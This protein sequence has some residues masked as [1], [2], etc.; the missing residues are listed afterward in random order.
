MKNIYSLLLT[1]TITTLSLFA[2]TPHKMSYQAIIRDS[3]NKLVVNSEI[4][5]RIS[6]LQGSVFGASVYIETLT[7]ETNANG[8]VT[9]EIGSE[10]ATV[11]TGDF[12]QINWSDG[13][14]FIKTETDPS[15]GTNYTITGT[16]QLLSVPFALHSGT[17]EILTGEITESQISDLQNYLTEEADPLF[18]ASPAYLLR[19][20]WKQNSKA[21]A[22]TMQRVLL[23]HPLNCLWQATAATAVVRFSM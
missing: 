1:V 23:H 14:Y 4:G 5:M 20:N 21:G 3:E 8:L 12:S 10:D 6:I 9:I 13:P 16:S 22:A 11:V 2:Q 7:P 17:A 15:G 19:P 18:E